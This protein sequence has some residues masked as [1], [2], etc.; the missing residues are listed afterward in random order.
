M[1]DVSAATIREWRTIPG[2]FEWDN[3]RVEP[4]RWQMQELELFCN[5][6]VKRISM[7]A[8]AGP[9]K[10]TV[11]AWNGLKALSCYGDIGEHP[12]GF[13]VSVT[14]DNLKSNLWPELAK[15]RSRSKYL[16]GA[17]DWTSKR[18]SSRDHPQTWFLE[19]RSWSK[20]A[21]SEEQ[22]RTLSG[23]HSKY[24]FVLIDESGDIP[25]TVIKA[26]EQ[27]LGNCIWGK[28][29]QGGNPTST[30]GI[31]HAAAT[32]LAHL[33]KVISVSGDPEN[34]DAWV[35][36]TRVGA[37]PAKWALEQINT[38]GRDNPWV[39]AYI[40]G[41]F[42]P[43]S[44]NTLLG[45]DEVDAAMRRHLTVDQYS[46]SQK[47]LGVDVARFGAD[48]TVIFPRQGLAA[49]LPVQMRNAKSH[50]IAGRI[51]AAKTKWHSEREFIDS[52]GGYSAGVEDSLSLGGISIVPVNF[53]SKA[54]DT[55][56]FNKRS[57]IIWKMCAWVKK[58]G[59]LPNIGQLK[60][61]LC[62][63]R[64]WYDG[65]K[66]RVVEKDQL[67]KDLG[68]LSPD[69]SD[70]L[71]VT[72]ADEDQPTALAPDGTPLNGGSRHVSDSE[73]APSDA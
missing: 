26:G 28:I 34:P 10:T 62:A 24:V 25:L 29:V 15:W 27:A 21:N 55:R 33:W 1:S 5:P 11:L 23:L 60:R 67:K 41:L 16:M 42:P 46:F 2:K 18:I 61:E 71:A 32:D 8:C 9:G 65:G 20:S 12:K 49:F 44:L 4:D 69:H 48:S 30:T 64:Y 73:N 59:A 17:F 39:M 3:F 68:G 47:R 58:G 51:V 36:S 56:Y 66:M 35:H 38:Y 53:S 14:A 19:A 22:G 70:A 72:F 37:E 54:M 43:S 7:Q 31:L 40:L 63:I 52:T 45:S 50:E 6:G 13:A 57:E